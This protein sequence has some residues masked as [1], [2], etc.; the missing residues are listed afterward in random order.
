[1]KAYLETSPYG[2]DVADVRQVLAQALVEV[3]RWN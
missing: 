2:E 1:L 3:A